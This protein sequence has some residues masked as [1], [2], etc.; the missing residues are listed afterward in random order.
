MNFC[1]Q[2]TND[3]RIKNKKNLKATHGEDDGTESDPMNWFDFEL[4]D[5][6]NSAIVIFDR[7]IKWLDCFPKAT[8]SEA[9]IVKAMQELTNPCGKIKQFYCDNGGELEAASRA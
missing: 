3:L 1:D 6:A 5:V 4:S 9:H 8:R 7:A 2:L